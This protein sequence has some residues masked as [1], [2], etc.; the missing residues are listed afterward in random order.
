MKWVDRVVA[1]MS[2]ALFQRTKTDGEE[3]DEPDDV[4]DSDDL[5]MKD[6]D[7]AYEDIRV[8]MDGNEDNEQK[9]EH[10]EEEERRTGSELQMLVRLQALR[11]AYG[12]RPCV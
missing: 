6:E 2:P 10:R 1:D 8:V 5:L 7:D 11:I 9:D 3:V 12:D 4:N